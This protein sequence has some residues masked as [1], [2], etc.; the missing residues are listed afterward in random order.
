MDLNGQSN[1][2]G[3]G[4]NM[5]ERVM[6]CADA[7]HILLSKRAADDLAEYERWRPYL[8]DLGD[9]EGKHGAKLS[10][11][12]FYTEEFGNPELPSRFKHKQVAK[13]SLANISSRR[14]KIMV[15]VGLLLL[16]AIFVLYF[17]AH[18]SGRRTALA[19]QQGA[20]VMPAAEKSI[21]V[22]PFENLSEKKSDANFANGVHDEILT[23][24]AKVSDLKVISRTSTMQYRTGME[25]NLREIGKALGAAHVV[26]G[27]VQRDG[28]RVRVSVQLIDARSDTHL[29]RRVMSE[30]WPI[31]L[32][33][34][35]SLPKPLSRNSRRNCRRKRRPRS[36]RNQPRIHWRTIFSSRRTL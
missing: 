13:A 35:V 29:G 5:A 21:A 19:N 25:R 4:M 2:A 9:C 20:A 12:N 23:D 32:R 16:G 22:L 7:N 3:G 18:S 1:V 11:V 36:K 8:H 28:R 24:L 6:S 10:L 15:G 33:S 34:K 31:P 27:S 30:M 17:L 26:E 14:R